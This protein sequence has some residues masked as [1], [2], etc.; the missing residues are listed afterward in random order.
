MS[1]SQTSLDS[2]DSAQFANFVKT[3]L[4]DSGIICSHEDQEVIND[5]IEKTLLEIGE[6]TANSS[7]LQIVDGRLDKEELEQRNPDRFQKFRDLANLNNDEISLDD[8]N[9]EAEAV[10][11]TIQHEDGN[12][13]KQSIGGEE[14]NQS[15]ENYLS[16]REEDTRDSTDTFYSLKEESEDEIF[17]DLNEQSEE[18]DDSKK[19]RK[20]KSSDNISF[21][22]AFKKFGNLG[23]D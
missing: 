18:E 7:M 5:A 6:G 17:S 12:L 23:N 21:E 15:G 16:I 3:N 22:K 9:M 1:D 19:S 20:S 10:L 11:D 4:Q 2:Q 8:I 13:S 14:S